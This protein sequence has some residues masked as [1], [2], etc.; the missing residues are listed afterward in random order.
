MASLDALTDSYEKAEASYLAGLRAGVE[1]GGLTGLAATVAQAANDW[2]TGAYTAFH[3][4]SGYDRTALDLLTERT[5]V[6]AEL[7]TDI[8]TAYQ[9]TAPGT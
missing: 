4:A 9:A 5:E 6:L 1:R 7:W 8:A 3:V 2:N